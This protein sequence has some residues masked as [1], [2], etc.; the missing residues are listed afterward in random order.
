VPIPCSH[1]VRRVAALLPTLVMLVMALATPA[2]AQK[3][4]TPSSTVSYSDGS[5]LN[6]RVSITY[7]VSVTPDNQSQVAT[8]SGYVTFYVQN[9]GTVSASFSFTVNCSCTLDRFSATIS[10]GPANGVQ[11]KAY[12][13]SYRGN[14]TLTAS[15]PGVSDTGSIILG[16]PT[17]TVGV[18]PDGYPDYW[19]EAGQAGTANFTVSNAGNS[20]A[21]YSLSGSCDP[22]A[23]GCSVPPASVT[24]NPSSYVPV[25][26]TFTAGAAGSSGYARLNASGPSSDGGTVHILVYSHTVTVAAP[27]AVSVDPGNYTASFYV[28]NTGN[29]ATTYNLASTCGG[30]ITGCSASLGQITVAAGGTSPAVSVPYT[31]VNRG[32]AGSVTLTASWAGNGAVNASAAM[33]VTVKHSYAVAVTPD[34]QGQIV[35]PSGSLTFFVQNLGSI[36][37]SFNLSVN[38]TPVCTLSAS[39]ITVNPGPASG[40]QVTVSLNGT[41]G[42]VILTASDAAHTTSDTGS[43]IITV[44]TYT[45]GVGPDGL[46]DSWFEAGQAGTANFTVSNVGNSPAT[47]SLSG[48]CDAVATG[49]SVAP[50]SVA[51]SPSSSTPV[52]I[53]FTAG[54]PG[55]SGYVRLNASGPSSDGGT[56]HVMVYSHT[57]A[58]NAPAAVSVDPGS[59]TASFTVT[60][61][62]NVQT[63]YNLGS[64]CSPPITGCSASLGQITVAAG[65]TSTP[66]SVPYTAVNR[67]DAGTVTLAAS[68]VGNGAVGGS[69]PMSV[70]VKHSYGIAVTPD[71]Q[72]QIVS[73]SGSVTFRL[74]NLG[75][76]DNTFNLSANCSPT[77]GIS[78][79][80]PITVLKG[81]VTMGRDVTVSLNGYTGTVILTVSDPAHGVSDTGSIIVTAPTYTVSA[82]PDTNPQTVAQ[83]IDANKPGSQTFNIQNLGNSPATYTISVSC[84]PS[85][86]SNCSWPASFQ[87]PSL[88]TLPLPVSFTA[89]S[90]GGVGTMTLT[91]SAQNTS[92]VGTA[93]WQVNTHYSLVTPKGGTASVYVGPGR[94]QVFRVKNTGN[95]TNSYTLTTPCLNAVTA[96]T[97]PASVSNLLAGDSAS[98]TVTYT[99]S[100]AG[101]G[102]A[103]L[104]TSNTVDPAAVD[105]GSVNVTARPTFTVAV[106]P[107]SAA[108]Q[109]DAWTAATVP[110]SITNNGTASGSFF[111]SLSCGGTAVQGTCTIGDFVN[112]TIPSGQSARV[113]V[114]FPAG[115]GRDTAAISI[116]ALS[117]DDESFSAS[118]SARV[119]VTAYG[120]AVTPKALALAPAANSSDTRR[121]TVTNTGTTR[122]TFN[123]QP[124]CAPPAATSCSATVTAL[125]LDPNVAGTT[126]VTYTAGDPGAEGTVRLVATDAGGR[127]AADGSLSVRVGTAVANNSVRFKDINPG[128]TIE[129]SQCLIFSIV[130]DVA[131]ECGALRIVHSLP[132]VR[133]LGKARV[134]TLIYSSDQTQGPT[135]AVNVTLADTAT[136][137]MSVQLVVVRTWPDSHLDTLTRTYAGSDWQGSQ[138]NRRRRL[139][140][141][142]VASGGT[143]I[144]RYSVAAWLMYPSGPVLAAPVDNSELAFVDRTGSPFGA[145]WWLAGLER[146][147]TGQPDTSVLWVA[148]DGSTR[149]YV[150]Q[151]TTTT[152]ATGTETDRDTV[153]LSPALDRPDTLLHRGDGTYHRQAGNGLFVEFD[154]MGLHRRTVNRLGYATVFTY[155]GS[156]RLDSL[157]LPPRTTTISGVSTA[158]HSYTFAYNAGS[159]LLETVTAP[160]VN[161]RSRNVIL[162][163]NGVTSKV[164]S[165]T[166]QLDSLYQVT[167]DNSPSLIYTRRTDRRGVPTFFTTET[168]S[169]TIA[170][171]ATGTGMGTDTVR[172]TFRTVGGIGAAGSTESLDSTYFRYDGPQ[173]SPVLDITKF[174]LDRFGAPV[175]IVNA[176]NQETRITRGDPRFPALVTET[177]G[178]KSFTTWAAYDAR[179]NVSTT[180]QVNPHGDV[181]PIDAT[182]TYA[183]HPKWDMVTQVIQPEGE[184][185]NISYDDAT[186]NR[187][188]QD[189]GRGLMSRVTFQYSATTDTTTG[190]MT[191]LLSNVTL[192]AAGTLSSAS[193]RVRYDKVGNADTSWTAGGAR[194]AATNDALGRTIKTTGLIYADST[195]VTETRTDYDL[196]DRVIVSTTLAS[197]T[198]DS[199]SRQV[200]VSSFYNR[201]GQLD[202]LWRE[203]SPDRPTTIFPTTFPGIGRLVSGW[204]YDNLG[205]KIAEV[206][207]DPTPNNLAD[208]PVDSTTY[209]LA[210]N[211]TSVTTRRHNPIDSLPYTIRMTYDVLGRLK[212]RT[213]PAAVYRGRLEG[214]P[215]SE[216]TNRPP[217]PRY[218]NNPL[219]PLNM[220]GCPF[221]SCGGYTVA[222]DVSTFDYDSTGNM[223]VADNSDARVRKD[224]YANGQVHF[225]TLYIRTLNRD[226]DHTYVIE[227]LYDRDGR[228]LTLKHP[229]QLSVGDVAQYQSGYQTG[230]RYDPVT[231]ALSKVISPRDGVTNGVTNFAYDARGQL[232]V[233]SMPRSI[234][235]NYTYDQD[236]DITRQFTVGINGSIHDAT[237]MYDLRGKMTKLMN[238][239]GAKDTT[240]TTYNGLGQVGFQQQITHTQGAVLL[241]DAVRYDSQEAFVYD[242]MGNR[243]FV[244]SRPSTNLAGG[245]P[246][247]YSTSKRNA[248]YEAGTGR[249][250]VGSTSQVNVSNRDTTEYDEAGNIVFTT[251]IRPVSS[252]DVSNDR[253]SYYGADGQLRAVDFR[254]Y[255]NALGVFE[256]YRYDALGR[257]VL[258][259]ARRECPAWGDYRV[260]CSTSFVRRTVWAGSQELYEI[261]MPDDAVTLVSGTPLR[262][263]DTAA[264]PHWPQPFGFFFDPNQ[265]FGRVAYTYGLKTDQPLTITRM[266]FADTTGNW[267]GP[268]TIVPLWTMRGYADT[269]YFAETGSTMCTSQ[270]RCMRVGFAAE[271]WMPVWR[272]APASTAFNG[273]LLV[274][275]ADA[276][277]Q[278]YRRSRY[279]DP[280]SGRFTQEDPIGLAGGLNAYGFA[281][282]D[283]VNFSDPFGLCPPEDTKDGPEC[284]K[285]VAVGATA[286]WVLSK[287]PSLSAGVI[288]YS[289]EGPGVFFTTG[290]HEGISGGVTGDLEVSKN[291]NAFNGKSDQGCVGPAVGAICGSRNSS[292][293]SVTLSAGYR[294]GP[295]MPATATLGKTVT[296]KLTWKD[297]RD[298]AFLWAKPGLDAM[299]GAGTP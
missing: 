216:Q 209:D 189:D 33:G 278:L 249:Q 150:N 38:C 6:G 245:G 92:D 47:Y 197:V 116:S 148:G 10:P 161:G 227:Y 203:Q 289:G 50:A 98:V 294:G 21:T 288:L 84:P 99:G 196:A 57:A 100:G 145:G 234:S 104:A 232:S 248:A 115:A 239:A 284:K 69:A 8:P 52:P 5:L 255:T 237:M 178:P 263:N 280:A 235:E 94:T 295:A 103:R 261:Q 155:D 126:D 238:A 199:I 257:R 217:Y 141:P 218:P 117:L 25:P 205:R 163:R 64:T 134:P 273:S 214:I 187:V 85:F 174:W 49:C 68:W 136:I 276:S 114:Q 166:E 185:T 130:P 252:P 200:T 11:V 56:V 142:N 192:P 123:L 40:V 140:V 30:Q 42:T 242:A 2:T 78:P 171:F 23:T 120:V 220:V 286:S 45:V 96:C 76:I 29:V 285:V 112:F 138:G 156:S 44:A 298:A 74:A 66:V 82:S 264:V 128:T 267:P 207:P 250:L 36:A 4:K 124:E 81:G 54:A 75:S 269:A 88:T 61:T 87:V 129:R 62:G 13:G 293:K 67:G 70:T 119:T 225:E 271:Y 272:F 48:S 111:L 201:E 102:T 236:G 89:A 277:G 168:L 262:E 139:A 270:F 3:N 34:S 127:S 228:V 258:V 221:T 175:R 106:T 162:G 118:G 184:I 80:T 108:P 121:F 149:K 86:F 219:V 41:T 169:P 109:V 274:D 215:K 17:Y 212:T 60:N 144:L 183:W 190:A 18:G 173:L 43:I 79:S 7:A 181:I 296:H 231:G 186:G 165:I 73:P 51:V 164:L 20:Q 32:D 233:I 283:P 254:K 265:Y 151:H 202:S 15:G 297:V 281:N 210:G 282:G 83:P 246:P 172:H 223:T 113:N 191:G 1:F 243:G 14:V 167:F 105:T 9:T 194:T 153:Y 291:M 159:G 46:P 59:Y 22:V 12:Y 137:P 31:A 143:G 107:D 35:S 39:T 95:V 179:G 240:I 26:I 93:K 71:S 37:T 24:V 158:A 133:T 292:G 177:R 193:S 208:N 152:T 188:S 180:T 195:H 97:A 19:F 110:F 259:E 72:G 198:N 247:T 28:T 226:A 287:G 182:T 279:Y 122:R 224:Y 53:T 244:D 65:A 154:G 131:S 253:A 266:A 241:N 157:Q 251:Q 206:A 230:M 125:T 147:Y 146:L 132:A 268:F 77:C 170:T 63:T 101:P 135:L 256:E 91:A 211:V 260:E 90:G 290:M 204:R 213:V 160:T 229:Q 27:A 16:S 176:L 58:V 55:S 299:I 222:G 275:K